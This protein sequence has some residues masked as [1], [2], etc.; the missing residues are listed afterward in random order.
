MIMDMTCPTCK[1]MGQMPDKKTCPDCGG[2]G[3]KKTGDMP[4]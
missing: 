2:T 3:M 4:H 1:G